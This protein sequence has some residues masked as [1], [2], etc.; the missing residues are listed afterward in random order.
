MTGGDE[1][2]EMEKENA[3]L[4]SKPLGRRSMIPPDRHCLT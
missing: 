4:S 1:D 3:V 2:R